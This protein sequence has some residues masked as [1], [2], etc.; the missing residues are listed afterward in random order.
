M[1][2]N[3]WLKLS[4]LLNDILNVNFTISIKEAI[5]GTLGFSYKLRFYCTIICLAKFYIYRTRYFKR[6]LTFNDMMQ[7]LCEYG[8]TVTLNYYENTS[9][10]S[11]KILDLWKIFLPAALDA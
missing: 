7:Y 9:T 3:I 8:R 1:V 5:F 2:K 11:S 6:R 4:G 10:I